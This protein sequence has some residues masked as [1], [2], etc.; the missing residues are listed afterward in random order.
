MYIEKESIKRV[1]V[2]AVKAVLVRR[3]EYL[4][5]R[6]RGGVTKSEVRMAAAPLNYSKD[7]EGRDV[8][9]GSGEI[10]HLAGQLA[11]LNNAMVKEAK[12]TGGYVRGACRCVVSKE[13][14]GNL[15]T[16]RHYFNVYF[17]GP[18][19]GIDMI[20]PRGP[21]C[22]ALMNMGSRDGIDTGFFSSGAIGMSRQL[23]ATD[24]IFSTLKEAG[25][26]YGQF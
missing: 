5:E 18:D 25:G 15:D 26:V 9:T 8:M 14:R 19:G 12:K 11:A 16:G 24:I 1:S 20:A 2:S 10:D 23:D 4:M 22:R 21:V 6:G 13:P 3:A 7:S 17:V